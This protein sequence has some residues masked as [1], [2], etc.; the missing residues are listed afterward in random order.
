M[1]QRASLTNDKRLR[2]EDTFGAKGPNE[3]LN[4]AIGVADRFAR[5]RGVAEG[6]D[7]PDLIKA[8]ALLDQW[9]RPWPSS[10]FQS[11]AGRESDPSRQ[12]FLSV[13]ARD[14]LTG[15]V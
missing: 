9:S 5:D 13:C 7:T 14:N 15:D 12:I 2:A 4:A 6:F 8:R 10:G 1:H 11:S 3:G